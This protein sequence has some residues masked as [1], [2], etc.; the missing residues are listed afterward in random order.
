MPYLVSIA[1]PSTGHPDPIRGYVIH[2]CADR[3]TNKALIDQRCCV[4]VLSKTSIKQSISDDMCMAHGAESAFPSTRPPASIR[5]LAI[6]GS[7]AARLTMHSLI[8]GVEPWMGS[9][10]D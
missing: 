4:R 5:A 3:N 9:S 7:L 6:L 10:T 8:S 2:D 1:F